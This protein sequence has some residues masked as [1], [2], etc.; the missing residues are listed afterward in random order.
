MFDKILGGITT[1]LGRL[2]GIVSII[3][4]VKSLFGQSSEKHGLAV[5][6]AKSII[7][8]TEAFSGKDIIDEERFSSGLDK[9]ISGIVDMLHAVGVLKSQS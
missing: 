1:V 3:D 8:E 6:L 2:P 7:L 4:T 9:C 5:S